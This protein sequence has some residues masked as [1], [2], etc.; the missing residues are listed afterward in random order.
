MR[1]WIL[2]AFLALLLA[3][4]LT[5]VLLA[6]ADSV[7][8]EPLGHEVQVDHG[9]YARLLAAHVHG[10][11]VD[12][13]GLK[14][15]Q[16]LLDQYLA[17]LARLDP[18]APLTPAWAAGVI[19]AYNAWTLRLILDHYPGIRSIKDIGGLFSSPWKQ[20]L[21]RL[22]DRVLT[23]DELEHDVIRPRLADPRVHMALNCTARSCPPLR[24]EP[25]LPDTLSTQLDD[26][27]RSFVN[28]PAALRIDTDTLRVSRIFKWYGE[29]FG[30]EAGVLT[31]L[32][33][34]AGPDLLARL[35]A[36]GP[37]PRLTYLDY[38]WTLNDLPR[39]APA[40]APA[41]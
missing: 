33:R 6:P 34:Y 10:R 27:V 29:D 4:L 35:A 30:G 31:F 40:H 13:A 7:A 3:P 37:D 19:N 36:L 9:P 1:P 18:D 41:P 8:S 14:R 11:S 15:D 21:V 2:T 5:A 32:R 20:H 22:A 25:Y 26:Q 16:A 12:Y 38:D 17:Q 23:L 24:P 28:D 39:D